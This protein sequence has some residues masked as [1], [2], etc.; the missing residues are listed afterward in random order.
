VAERKFPVTEVFGPT[1]Q[2]EGAMAGVFTYFV[3]FGGCDYR[4]WWCD[5]SFSVIPGKVKQEAQLITRDEILDRLSELPAGP[6]WVTLSGGNP[7][8]LQLED[9]VSLLHHNEMKVAV[10]TQGSLYKDWLLAV[11]ELTIS[12]K[13][14]SS[15][16]NGKPHPAFAGLLEGSPRPHWLNM[17]IK[18]PV[19][20][21][22]DY[23]WAVGVHQ[24]YPHIPFYFSIVTRM[25]GL[26]G[27]FD[28]G[29]IDSTDDILVRYKW[30]IERASQDARVAGARAFPQLHALVWGHKR[31]V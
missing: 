13:P 10:E 21:D 22:R 18:I 20:D 11:D 8:L 23:E 12:L 29:A 1:V 6:D 15:G 17:N 27:D 5:T 16:M 9:L 14:P 26:Y 25:G 4:C 2:G 28:G 19:F 24:R 7:A 3:R 31:G 30:L